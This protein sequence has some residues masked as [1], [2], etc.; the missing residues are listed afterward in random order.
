M[1]QFVTRVDERL[2]REID[3]LVAQGVLASRSEAVRQGLQELI[4]RYRRARTGRAI[5]EGYLRVPQSEAEVGWADDATRR[6]I[7]DEPW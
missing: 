2:A 4:E 5:V 7:R 6:M 3:E 1:V